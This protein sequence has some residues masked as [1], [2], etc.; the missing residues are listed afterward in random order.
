MGVFVLV[1]TNPDLSPPPKPVAASFF[2]PHTVI[3]RCSL[4]RQPESTP[5][6]YQRPATRVVPPIPSS[7]SDCCFP[8]SPNRRCQVSCTW[9][10]TL[11]FSPPLS[12]LLR[13]DWKFILWFLVWTLSLLWILLLLPFSFTVF[14]I[15]VVGP[16]VVGISDIEL[17]LLFNLWLIVNSY[18]IGNYF[19]IMPNQLS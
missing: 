15:I 9:V 6:G 10:S 19:Q 7:L 17:L 8:C 12:P 3:P 14:E 11:F 16:V 1:G 5:G 18:D 13:L 4:P 2:S